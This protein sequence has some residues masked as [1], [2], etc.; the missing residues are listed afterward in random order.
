[1]LTRSSVNFSDVPLFT[2]NVVTCIRT[3]NIELFYSEGLGSCYTMYSCVVCWKVAPPYTRHSSNANHYTVTIWHPWQWCINK[4]Q[5]PSCSHL[6]KV[7]LSQTKTGHLLW[8]RALLQIDA[9]ILEQYAAPFSSMSYCFDILTM[10][11]T[12]LFLGSSHFPFTFVLIWTVLC[13]LFLV[14]WNW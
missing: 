10:K 4:F 14:L 7:Y 3:S 12:I 11:R 5:I 1:M 2:M 8:C 9:I 13:C 6:A